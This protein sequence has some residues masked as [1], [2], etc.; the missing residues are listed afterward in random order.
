MTIAASDQLPRRT[1]FLGWLFGI[2]AL[3][4]NLL[5]H[6]RPADA[7]NGDEVKIGQVNTGSSPTT[8]TA[9]GRTAFRAIGSGVDRSG[10]FAQSSGNG[11]RGVTGVGAIGVLGVTNG[12]GGFGV[13]GNALATTGAPRAVFGK[14]V[15]PNGFGVLSRNLATSGSAVAVQGETSS[16]NG[17][18]VLGKATG[19]AANSNDSVGVAG[20]DAGTGVL[21][22]GKRVGVLG[23]APESGAKAVVASALADGTI[24]LD[25]SSLGEGSIAIKADGPVQFSSSGIATITA[26]TSQTTV[27]PEV[28]VDGESKILC[29]LLNDP[30]TSRLLYA[31]PGTDSFV[32]HM[33]QNVASNVKVAWF[34]ID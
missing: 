22:L 32:I 12:S 11:S 13:M 5:G 27:T 16:P 20:Q 21:G 31:D 15:A 29:T 17:T 8:I 33:T 6:S 34:V 14:A 26:G 4:G 9:P 3:A 23:I 1:M 18:A 30:G 10:V 7:A 28:P 19:S 25:V 2:A 24:A